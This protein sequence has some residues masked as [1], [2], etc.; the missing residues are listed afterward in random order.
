MGFDRGRRGRGRDKRDGFGE[1]GFDPFMGGP[2]RFGGGGDRFGGGGGDRFGGGGGG[3][4]RSGGGFSG[5]P[6][7]GP[8]GGGG[9]GN[10]PVYD[11]NVMG[12][13]GSSAGAGGGY[14]SAGGGYAN[15]AAAGSGYSGTY[16]PGA[17]PSL[18]LKKYLPGGAMAQQRDTTSLNAKGIT[19]A[20]GLSNWEKVTRSLNNNRS[21][22][23]KP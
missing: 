3:G 17:N 22:L 21:R 23:V 2:D 5:G 10:K 16:K 11:T 4:H 15:G 12:G 8:G 1:D 13:V 7:G 19:P 9:G 14:P 18:D 6:R 20:N